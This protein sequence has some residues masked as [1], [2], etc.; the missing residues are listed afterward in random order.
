[1]NRLVAWFVG[2]PVTVNLITLFVLVAGVFGATGLRRE[3]FPALQL[4]R[5]DVTV[6]YPGAGPSEVEE[7][8]LT[9]LEAA[10]ADVSA[11]SRIRSS[12]C[13]YRAG[14]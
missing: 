14:R 12:T 11:A 8:V 4:S 1:M 13:R 3:I 9:R 10:V 5:V 7:G 6:L 2:N